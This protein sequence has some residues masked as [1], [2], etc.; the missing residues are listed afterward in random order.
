MFLDEL[1]M[2]KTKN[3]KFRFKLNDFMKEGLMR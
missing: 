3:M 2:V 1:D